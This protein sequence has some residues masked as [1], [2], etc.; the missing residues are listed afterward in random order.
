MSLQH[1]YLIPGLVDAEVVFR[2]AREGM[3][4]NRDPHS[5][6]V[7]EHLHE[8]SCIGHAHTV[9]FH[10]SKLVNSGVRVQSKEEFDK[11]FEG[12]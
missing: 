1:D 9:Y 6:V 8:Q 7:H 2:K 12:G 11:M 3:V 5:T 10:T 4:D